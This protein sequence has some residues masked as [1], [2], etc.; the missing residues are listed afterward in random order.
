MT[1]HFG[2]KSQKLMLQEPQRM[3]KLVS[4]HFGI[5]IARRAILGNRKCNLLYQIC[6]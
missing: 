1:I 2:S 6:I 4:E 5:K 3:N